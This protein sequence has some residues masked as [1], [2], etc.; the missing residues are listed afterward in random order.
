V[1]SLA[2]ATID[3]RTNSAGLSPKLWLLAAVVLQG[4]AL[5]MFTGPPS[6]APWPDAT[7]LAARVSPP[8]VLE[9]F[10]TAAATLS[11]SGMIRPDRIVPLIVAREEP[12]PVPLRMASDEPRDFPVSRYNRDALDEAVPPTPN[13]HEDGGVQISEHGMSANAPY[14]PP[15][16]AE[17][18]IESGPPVDSSEPLE[19]IPSP[20]PKTLATSAATS[21]GA[22]VESDTDGLEARVVAPSPGIEDSPTA[23]ASEREPTPVNVE[24]EAPDWLVAPSGKGFAIQLA[25]FTSRPSALEFLAKQGL[26]D[27]DNVVVVATN[28]RGRQWHAVLLGPYADKSAAGTASSAVVAQYPSMTPWIRSIRSIA[29]ARAQ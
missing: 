6:Q 24:A 21:D 2:Q 23:R 8:S 9:S 28:S 18:I 15:S 17:T 11:S 3:I 29:A 7:S 13:P 5:A 25:A 12:V 20:E 16:A 26:G 14:S 27:R 1:S 4:A 22:T 19:P 10:E